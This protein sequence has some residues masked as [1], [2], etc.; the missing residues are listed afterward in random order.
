[1]KKLLLLSLVL[2]SSF[3]SAQVLLEDNFNLLTVGDIPTEI[4]G[5]TP[6]QGDYLFFAS[7][8]TA[9]TT[10]VN[11]A[12]SNA[13]IVAEGNGSLGFLL[14]GPNGDKGSRY[15]WK[16]G[17]PAIWA[18][19]TV[20]N[21]IIEVEV[22]INPGDGTTL[23]RNTFGVYIFNPAGNVLAGFFVRAAT[24][25]LFVVAYSTP[26]G[27]PVGNYNYALAAAPGIQIPASVFSRIGV[28]YNTVTGQ[29]RIKG[30]GIAAAGLTVNGSAVGTAPDEIDFISFSGNTTASPNSTEATMVMDN[31]LVKASAT[32]SLLG[33]NEANEVATFSVFPNPSTNNFTITS[34][35]SSTINGV[36]MF[37]INGRIVKSLEFDNLSSAD[38]NIA[39]L[40]QGVYMLKISSDNGSVTQKVIKQ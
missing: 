2:S 11:S 15:M 37:D 7:N 19:R 23:S 26:T 1:M 17:F 34:S 12:V 30:P 25:E 16:A 38:V 32:D 36:E 40:S 24:R 33:V 31:F 21:D 22:D 4:T 14:E 39:D 13:Q 29:V 28:S 27:N 6:G 3:A 5:T 18:A 8:G 10:T 20:A 9:P 35:N